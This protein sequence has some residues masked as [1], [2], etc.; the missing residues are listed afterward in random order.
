MYK[1]VFHILMCCCTAVV[2]LAAFGFS[3]HFIVH[4]L[5]VHIR[6]TH[7]FYVYK[8][9][10]CKY[11]TQYQQNRQTDTFSYTQR[12]Q[13]LVGLLACLFANLRARDYSMRLLNFE[14]KIIKITLH[15]EKKIEVEPNFEASKQASK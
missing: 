11:T 10:M 3:F 5:V 4:R 15:S 6:V 8:H 7:T 9:N 12:S 1:V 14:S 2:V 13:F